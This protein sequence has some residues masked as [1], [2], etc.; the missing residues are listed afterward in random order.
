MLT[1]NNSVGFDLIL[2][3]V[4]IQDDLNQ[5][6]KIL[7]LLGSISTLILS[8][9]YLQRSK[10]NKYEYYLLILFSVL[11]LNLLVSS[12]DLL[13][14]Y[15]A[16]ELQALS[17]YVLAS[18]QRRSVFSTEAG[19]KYFILGAFSSGLI[20]YGF[21]LIYGVT[22]STNLTDLKN[23]CLNVSFEGS[24]VLEIAIIFLMA[25]FLFKIAAFPFH[26]WS[27]DVYEGAPSSSTT[28]FAVVPKLAILV[29][30]SRILLYSFPAY[31]HMWGNILLFSGLGSIVYTAFV[32][33]KQDS[34]K[35]LLAYSSVG[36]VGFILIALSTNTLEGLE[37]L[38]FYSIVYMV[39]SIPT[40]GLVVSCMEGKNKAQNNIITL[41][42]LATSS[43][44][45]GF[46]GA[47]ALFSLA[48]IPPLAGFYSKVFIFFLAIKN[49]M[50]FVAFLVLG[51]S[52]ISTF[53]YIF[54]IKTIYFEK[55][56]NWI[57]C[58]K[59]SK[60]NSILLAI[61]L[62]LLFFIFYNPESVLLISKQM[63]LTLLDPCI[64]NGGLSLNIFSDSFT[65]STFIEVVW[66][67][68]AGIFILVTA[69]L[70][71]V[72][73]IMQAPFF[74]DIFGTFFFIAAFIFAL[75]ATP[76]SWLVTV[77]VST[78]IYI[79]IWV[80]KLIMN[81]ILYIFKFILPFL[82]KLLI[83]IIKRSG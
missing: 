45:M 56:K 48:G 41:A 73:C 29:F 68:V 39:T 50:Y 78:V 74:L 60:G 83:Y 70:T 2:Q 28:F 71:L 27:P 72:S 54:V 24:N 25:G 16:I 13:S 75:I 59:I 1:A 44:L 31:G 15:L 46:L 49:S 36:H 23:F 76:I 12:S 17:F 3:R 57:F 38:F 82:K 77:I 64:G 26:M 51:L 19:L 47:I 33:I 20:L 63:S 9:L 6:A 55:K 7:L 21:S 18:F 66:T 22:G 61:S 53:Y 32:A 65:I 14:A 81:L 10:L 40:W 8:Q 43:P 67:I 79:L 69:V 35:R 52:V 80:V 42:G 11:G 4:Y 62:V 30:L 37:A 34:L 58:N 5:S